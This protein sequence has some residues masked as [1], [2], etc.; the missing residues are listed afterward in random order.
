VFNSFAV[1]RLIYIEPKKPRKLG[2]VPRKGAHRRQDIWPSVTLLAKKRLVEAV[3]VKLAMPSIELDGRSTTTIPHADEPTP[4]Q[5]VPAKRRHVALQNAERQNVVLQLA[6]VKS[7]WRPT[8]LRA[9][10]S[11]RAFFMRQDAVS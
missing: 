5:Q 3:K 6:V 8:L 4:G 2:D 7:T 9:R 1:V 11:V 10:T